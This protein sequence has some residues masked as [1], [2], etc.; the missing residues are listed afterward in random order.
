MSAFLGYV[1]GRYSV[2]SPKEE[3]DLAFVTDT[4]I[5]RDTIVVN[6]R[7]SAV[8]RGSG[9][10]ERCLPIA[11]SNG[12]GCEHD[13]DSVCV[14]VPIDT[15][16]YH[17]NNFRAVISGYEARI[18]TLQLFRTSE[19]IRETI[20]ITRKQSRWAVSCGAGITFSRGGIFPG[21][22]V[23]IGYVLHTF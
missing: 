10:V 11:E 21:A 18:D 19:T 15:I 7:G 13:S 17:D 12:G 6:H 1:A 3:L 2:T 20:K 22:Y 4:V 5:K 23:G 8:K 16:I 9:Y 14:T